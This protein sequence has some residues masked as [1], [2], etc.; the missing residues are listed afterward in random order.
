MIDLDFLECPV[1]ENGNIR[2][3][4]EGFD[5][6]GSFEPISCC[7]Y[8]LLCI[9]CSTQFRFCKDCSDKIPKKYNDTN[10]KDMRLKDQSKIRVQMMIFLGFC[11][12]TINESINRII[13]FNRKPLDPT[14][15][16]CYGKVQYYKE[17][18]PTEILPPGIKE[19]NLDLKP[20][21]D[22]LEFPGRNDIST[23]SQPCVPCY[24]GDLELTYCNEKGNLDKLDS[25]YNDYYIALTGC[26]GGLPVFFTCPDCGSHEE[27]TDK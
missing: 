3:Y 7:S 18:Y 20:K 5:F 13:R 8:N 21:Y 10:I 14:T 9:K 12:D 16:D 24:V 25:K 6:T 23:I 17:V 15:D 1:C 11:G 26:S 19:F 27:I 2:Y 4:R 22:K